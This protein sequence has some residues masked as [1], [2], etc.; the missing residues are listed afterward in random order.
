MSDFL[1]KCFRT[2]KPKA[3]F[4]FLESI[5]LIEVKHFLDILLITLQF[6]TFFN[7]V[8]SLSIKAS[9]NSNCA[10]ITINIWDSP[11]NLIFEVILSN[12]SYNNKNY[13]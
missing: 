10:F 7:L 13:S 3:I 12:I 1:Y 8:S 2:I 6:R 9:I 11:S 4:V 5:S